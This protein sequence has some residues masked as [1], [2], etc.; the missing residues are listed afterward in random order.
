MTAQADDDNPP[1]LTC[2][3]LLLE[4][5]LVTHELLWMRCSSGLLASGCNVWSFRAD[6]ST[7]LSEM[8]PLKRPG[9]AGFDG[10]TQ[11]R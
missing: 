9:Q 7:Q 3:L 5:S 11:Q 10:R 6:H 4:S 8:F 2:S 1:A